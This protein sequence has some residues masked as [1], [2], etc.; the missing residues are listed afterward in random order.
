MRTMFR[1]FHFLIRQI[2]RCLRVLGRI[3]CRP[4][5]AAC[6]SNVVFDPLTSMFS[7]STISIGN[8]VFIGGRAWFSCTH[9]KIKIGSHIMFGPNV[10]ILGG[11]HRFSH[12][13]IYMHG[14]TEKNAGDDAGVVIEDDVWIGA[15]SVILE[16][17]TLGEGSVIGAGSV[18][19]KSTQPYSISAGVPAK[20]IGN[21]FTSDQIKTHRAALHIDLIND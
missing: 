4:S 13:G 1:L 8:D 17:V 2:E 19:T 3:L 5:F 9:G 16:G 20:P 7:Y 6:G 11:N 18:V 21:R 14:D 10:S 15:N 12:P